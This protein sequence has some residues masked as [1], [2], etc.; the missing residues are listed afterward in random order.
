MSSVATNNKAFLC[1]G[2]ED[3]LIS[4]MVSKAAKSGPPN[5]LLSSDDDEQVSDS[6]VHTPTLSQA[7]LT[8]SEDQIITDPYLTQFDLIVNVFLHI[9]CCKTCMV[10]LTPDSLGGHM[11]NNH[12]GFWREMDMQK[13]VCTLERLGVSAELPV[14]S[15]GEIL[16]EIQGLQVYDGL[17]CSQCALVRL[18][19]KSMLEHFSHH[20]KNLKP[21][22]GFQ[23][24]KAQR[25]TSGSG[26]SSSFFQITVSPTSAVATWETVVSTVQ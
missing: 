21:P 12:K 13:A 2:N 23:A 11:K 8:N 24:C 18:N 14:V 25:L 5:P 7:G 17:V 22:V 1:Q 19:R 15:A 16:P 20:H 4:A 9:A 26:T 3:S 6:E 10:A